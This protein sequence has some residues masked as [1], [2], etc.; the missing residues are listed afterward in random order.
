MKE[1]FILGCLLAICFSGSGQ[2]LSGTWEGFFVS[3]MTKTEK[4]FSF[5][6]HT[7]QKGKAL[8]AVY[9]TGKSYKIDS[10]DCVCNIEGE[11]VANKNEI[12]AKMYKD[13]VIANLISYQ[14][15]AFINYFEFN[16]EQR[17]D[18]EYLKGKWFGFTE[19]KLR[20]DGAGGSVLL[21]RVSMKPAIGI[22]QYFPKLG[23]L[24][25]KY[26]HGDTSFQRSQ[27]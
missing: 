27:N 10:A 16:Y 21:K 20:S 2:N 26:N 9:S 4:Q 19:N 15:C 6:L 23:Q 8:W 11:L 13:K 22:D 1:K 25:T 18:G 12:F 17:D 14:I 7:Q 24:I 3:N 5:Y